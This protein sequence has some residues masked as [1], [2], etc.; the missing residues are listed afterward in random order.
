LSDETLDQALKFVERHLLDDGLF[1]ANV[2]IGDRQDGRWQGFPV[3]WRTFDF[4][5][6][7]CSRHALDI[8]DLGPLRDLGHIGSAEAMSSMRMLKISKVRP[9]E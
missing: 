2:N 5:T 7:A 3:V 4:Y 9:K 1:L 6:A 8:T